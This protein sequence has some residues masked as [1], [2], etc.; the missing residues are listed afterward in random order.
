MFN[1]TNQLDKILPR[2]QIRL[3]VRCDVR[4]KHPAEEEDHDHMTDLHNRHGLIRKTKNMLEHLFAEIENNHVYEFTGSPLAINQFEKQS[5]YELPQD[6]KEFYRRYKTV[7]LFTGEFVTLYRFVPI[8]EIKI[9]ALNIYGNDCPPDFIEPKTWFTVCDLQ[10][11]NYIA[12][13]LASKKDDQWNYIDCFHETY[14]TPGW[15]KVIARSFK[16]LLENSLKCGGDQVYHLQEG[17]QGY[18]DGMKIMPETAIHRIEPSENTRRPYEVKFGWS[19]IFV[20]S[21]KYYGSFF[22]DKYYGGKEKAFEAA[23]R[24]MNENAK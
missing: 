12:I 20:K 21:E 1:G 14:A 4:V 3:L 18:G 16:E 9:T 11:G 5:G 15:C 19:V 8:E 13:D 7:S 24:Y 22:A 6:L 10:D 2:N 17:F 23:K